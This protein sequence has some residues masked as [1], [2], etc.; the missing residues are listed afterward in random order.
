MNITAHL[1]FPLFDHPMLSVLE[2]ASQ[3]IFIPIT[4]RSCGG[5][6]GGG[7]LGWR[8]GRSGGCCAPMAGCLL[9]ANVAWGPCQRLH[10]LWCGWMW[11]W[12][13][14]W[15]SDRRRHSR[16]HRQHGAQVVCPGCGRGLFPGR[17][18]QSVHRCVAA[19]QPAAP[20]DPPVWVSHTPVPLSSVGCKL[21]LAEGVSARV[22]APQVATRCWRPSSTMPTAV[23]A[24]GTPPLSKSR[25]CTAGKQL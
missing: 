4:V 5:S 9:R 19:Q 1:G 8:D 25:T 2:R 12:V 3:K 22:V 18:R 11:V 16:L 17:C 20:S 24:G 23:C 6:R 10:V 13:W 14:V 15:A 21:W 7:G